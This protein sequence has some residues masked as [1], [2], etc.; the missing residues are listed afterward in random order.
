MGAY[1]AAKRGVAAERYERRDRRQAGVD[2][3]WQP[4]LGSSAT[5]GQPQPGAVRGRG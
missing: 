4:S 5:G 1:K 3:Y 2:A